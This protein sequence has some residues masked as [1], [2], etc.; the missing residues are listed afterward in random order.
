METGNGGEGEGG[1]AHVGC[2]HQQPAEQIAEILAGGVFKYYSIPLL[3]DCP[4]EVQRAAIQTFFTA[5]L[6]GMKF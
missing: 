2:V 3:P 1:G 6:I 4:N 5:F